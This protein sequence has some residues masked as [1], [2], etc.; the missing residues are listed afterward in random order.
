MTQDEHR[1]QIVEQFT[2]LAVPFSQMPNQSAELILAAAAVEPRDTVLDVA[3]GPGLM[4]CAFAA[5]VRHVTGIDLT[6]A[7]IDRACQLQAEKGLT[8]LAWQVGDVQRLPYADGSFSLVFTR[9]SFH[10]FLEPWAVLAEMVR[11]CGPGGRVVLVDVFTTD[12]HQAEA[13]NRM[14][15][16]RDPSHVRAL[17][18]EELTELLPEAGLE[19]I[20]T[21]F[22]KHEFELEQVLAGSFPAAGDT[23]CLRQIFRDDLDKNLLGLGMCERGGQRIPDCDPGGSKSVG[24]DHPRRVAAYLICRWSASFARTSWLRL[25]PSASASLARAAWSDLGTRT[26]NLPLY[27]RRCGPTGGSGKASIMR[28]ICRLSVVLAKAARSLA[29]GNSRVKGPPGP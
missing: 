4:A 2:K 17:L 29:P 5:A 16:L 6:P 21:Q 8:N 22:Y 1:R 18:L 19:T 7:M 9:Y 14:E 3:C 10:H 11:V 27:S 23:E 25:T 24:R 26:L 12:P 13:F 15:K 20:N 28:S